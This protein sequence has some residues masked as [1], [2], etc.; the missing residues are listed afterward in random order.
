MLDSASSEP[1]VAIINLPDVFVFE[2]SADLEDGLT[3]C[4]EGLD[5]VSR[6][7]A[8]LGFDSTAGFPEEFACNGDGTYHQIYP[9][10]L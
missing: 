3:G 9:P 2:S 4:P 5:S 8:V 1:I 10:E 6:I 7:I